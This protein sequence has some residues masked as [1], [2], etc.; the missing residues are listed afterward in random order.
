MKFY[1]FELN[2][3][4]AAIELNAAA[5]AIMQLKSTFSDSGA[6]KSYNFKI[7]QM[8]GRH[9]L[10]FCIVLFGLDCLASNLQLDIV[11]MLL[12]DDETK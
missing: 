4:A 2:A 1:A 9:D 8:H 6:I 12:G 7:N 3:A 11:I 10:V 5:A